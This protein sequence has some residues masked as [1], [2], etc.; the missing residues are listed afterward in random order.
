MKRVKY[1]HKET[2]SIDT[3]EGWIASYD[4][5]ELEERNLTAEEAFEEDEDRT[6]F[7]IKN[8]SDL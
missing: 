6:I 7:E 2:G 4:R 3:K 5:D 1:M 8:I